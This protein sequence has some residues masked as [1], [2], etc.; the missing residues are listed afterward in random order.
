LS[1]LGLEAP[2]PYL[3]QA[4]RKIDDTETSRLPELQELNRH[5]SRALA[6]QVLGEEFRNFAAPLAEIG[7]NSPLVIVAGGRLI[8]FRKVD[9]ATLTTLQEFRSTIFNRLLDEMDLQG[10]KFAFDPRPLLQLI[11]ALG[12]VDVEQH[13]FQKSAQALLGRRIDEILATIDA[14]PSNGIATP[15]PKPV[16]VLPDVLSDYLLEERCIGPWGRSTQYADR[17]CDLFGAHW[18]SLA[19]ESDAQPCGARL[20]S[21]PVMGDRAE[22]ARRDLGRH[23]PT[24]P[25]GRRIR[26][27]RSSR[28]FHLLRSTSRTT[29]LRSREQRL[30]TLS[31]QISQVRAADT[32]S[33]R[34][35]FCSPSHAL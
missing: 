2:L 24:L 8:P 7:S 15:R 28:I 34:T 11:A 26:A 33:A 13:D 10:P 3:Q 6:E 9:P 27:I 32:D 16:R 4:Q 21:R 23:S 31:N 22:S 19:E 14:L 29:L 17:V 12:L 25:R 35:T 1:L 30:T 18:R 20:A 5:Q